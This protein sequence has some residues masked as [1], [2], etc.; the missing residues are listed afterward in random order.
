MQGLIEAGATTTPNDKSGSFLREGAALDRL[1]DADLLRVVLA[2]HG[3]S[4]T[5]LVG[6]TGIEP[7]TPT[8]SR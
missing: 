1:T 2:D 5:A 3:S 8:V 4:K 7:V 6:D